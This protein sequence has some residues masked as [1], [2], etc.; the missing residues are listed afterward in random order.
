MKIG[1][2][3]GNLKSSSTP[4][5]SIFPL[6]GKME[7]LVACRAKWGQS[8]SPTQSRRSGA[9]QPKSQLHDCNTTRTRKRTSPMH[10]VYRIQSTSHTQR[11]YTGFTENLKQRVKDH[12]AGK[13]TSTREQGP[14]KL[15]FYSAFERYLKTGSGIAFAQKRLWPDQ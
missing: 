8:R 1:A 12:N 15:I 10:Y 9:L 6:R 11:G 3:L 7:P 4:A 5:T 2:T 13:I 14:W